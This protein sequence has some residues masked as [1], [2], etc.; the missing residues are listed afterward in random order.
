VKGVI[1]VKHEFYEL[2]RGTGCVFSETPL[3]PQPVEEQSKQILKALSG[4][5]LCSAAEERGIDGGKK[6]KGANGTS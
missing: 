5:K 6:Q 3:F 1:Q 2:D 4:L